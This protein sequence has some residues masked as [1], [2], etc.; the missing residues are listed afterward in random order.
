M[1]T[2]EITINVN[3]DLFKCQY[4]MQ[5]KVNYVIKTHDVRTYE[6]HSLYHAPARHKKNLYVNKAL[7]NLLNSHKDSL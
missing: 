5:K 4:D 7:E 2:L 1:S 3:K 6:I